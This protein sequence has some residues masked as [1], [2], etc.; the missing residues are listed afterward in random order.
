MK[1][2]LVF[3]TFISL[4]SM[5]VNVDDEVG[6]KTRELDALNQ[7]ILQHRDVIGRT[8]QQAHSV[9][10]TIKKIEGELVRQNQL[11]E[12]VNGQIDHTKGEIGKVE[13]DLFNERKKFEIAQASLMYKV[14]QFHR[15][16]ESD[17]IEILFNSDEFT[18]HLNELYFF[19]TMITTNVVFLNDVREKKTQLTRQ[20]NK[21]SGLLG[22]LKT[23]EHQIVVIKNVINENK[24]TKERLYREL[25]EQK[26]EYE[27][28]LHQLEKDS[29]QIQEMIVRLQKQGGH[30]QWIGDGRFIW[31]VVGKITSY[32]GKR[33]HPIFKTESFHTG[34]DI[35]APIGRPVFA[36]SEG[37]VLY[38][39][40][41]GGYG[42][43]V[44]ID[45]GAG[46]TS[47]YGHLSAF[48]VKRSAK[49]TKG[50]IIALVGSTG[51]STGPHLH[52]EIRQAGKAVDPL[53]YLPSR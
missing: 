43:T 31:P 33:V 17:F 15:L 29:E 24:K 44:V 20:E 23:Q 21:L 19:E 26:A 14:D 47:I 12:R 46:Y 9:Q 39:G 2:W 49:V 41:W 30:T 7:R 16:G 48:Y 36:A 50:Q 27:K 40:N 13:L 5:A 35:G 4:V 22:T 38:S 51:W 34:I 28:Q 8:E 18:E 32:F 3:F 10:R 11:H 6:K 25:M 45:H 42:K 1:R 52:F 37:V 53:S